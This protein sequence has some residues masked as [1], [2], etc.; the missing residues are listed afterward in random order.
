MTTAIQPTPNSEATPSPASAAG[1]VVFLGNVPFRSCWQRAQHLALGLA[2]TGPVVYVDPNFSFLQ[3]WRRSPAALEALPADSQLK[4][5]RPPPG[6]PLARSVPGLLRMNSRRTARRLMRYLRRQGFGLP[7]AVVATFPDHWELVRMLPGHVPVVYDVMDDFTLFL[8]FWQT[9]A[10]ERMHRRM[11]E[12]AAVVTTSS[13]VLQNQHRHRKHHLEYVSNGAPAGLTEQCARC[14]PDAVIARLPRPRLGYVGMISHWFD[15]T[16]VRALAE[17]F[18]GGS[19]VL[20]GPRDVSPPRR[21]RNLHVLGPIR[22]DQLP[23]V[24]RAFDLGLVPFVPGPAIDAVNP[25]KL[26]EYL[27]AGL[28]VLSSAFAEMQTHSE[29][30]SLY[31]GPADAVATAR[32]LLAAG[33]QRDRASERRLVAGEHTWETATG[34][35][36]HILDRAVAA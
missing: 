35:L 18:A 26:Y 10:Y 4:V 27:A 13:R 34:Q 9:S 20:V 5:F 17:A 1:V 15:W 16:V 32:R 19:V 25:I 33:E 30:V 28:P 22:Q 31:H 2:R 24:L 6:L 7:R 12:R 29:K 23:S 14:E 8:R 11:L 3:C 21:P 36:R